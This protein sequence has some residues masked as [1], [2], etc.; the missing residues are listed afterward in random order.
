MWFGDDGEII[1]YGSIWREIDESVKYPLITIDEAINNT[2]K[3]M[4]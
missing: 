1:G 4:L 3:E 2:K